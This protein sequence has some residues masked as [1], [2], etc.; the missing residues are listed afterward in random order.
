MKKGKT[1]KA[2]IIPSLLIIAAV[3]VALFA[4]LSICRLYDSQRSYVS[5]RMELLLSQ[6]NQSLDMIADKYETLLYEFCTDDE[7]VELIDK[8]NEEEMELDIRG[9]Q[10]RNELSRMCNRNEGINGIAIFLDNGE[11]YFY[12][13]ISGS[14]LGT[15]WITRNIPAQDIVGATY[16]GV[17]FDISGESYH[18]IQISRRLIDYRNIYKPL[19]V[20]VLS[21]D[22]SLIREVLPYSNTANIFLL[23]NEE[24]IS[25]T[26]VS[27]MGATRDRVENRDGYEYREMQNEKTK[28][29]VLN[30][31]SMADF[32][33]DIQMMIWTCIG[34]SAITFLIIFIVAYSMGNAVVGAIEEVVGGMERVWH[35]DFEKRIAVSEKMPVEIQAIGDG[36][37][38]M[39]EQIESLIHQV[40][41]AALEQKNAEIAALEAQIDPHFLYNTLDAIN[42]KSIENEQYEISEMVGAL[43]D[44]LRYTIRNAGEETTVD[45]EMYWLEQ[46]AMLQSVKLGHPV[47]IQ[48][49]IPEELRHAKLHKLLLQPFVENA[50][51][52]GFVHREEDCRIR[53]QLE[54]ASDKLH[55]LIEDNGRGIAPEILQQL[56]DES[57]EMGIHLGVGNVRS[58]LKLYYGEQASVYFES[59]EG[60]YTRVHLSIPV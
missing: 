13:R 1:L 25:A 8:I 44:I 37:N 12:D 17:E 48:Q 60:T 7:I 55:I 50:I 5:E 29:T 2:I 57:A 39:A 49:E 16:E 58:R 23:Q 46:Y 6:T 42:W 54:Q 40:R 30:Q 18:M 51:K 53:I 35:G 20:V 9:N 21:I 22:E 3:P 33:H 47:A 14:S 27:M 56:N 26:E 28:W 10:I 34:I 38:E 59:Q 19:G 36:Y 11:T 15:Q 4:I 31:Y 43:A 41:Q 45:K 32:R 24:V 52:H